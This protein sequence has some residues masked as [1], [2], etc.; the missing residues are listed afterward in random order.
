MNGDSQRNKVRVP[1]AFGLSERGPV[2]MVGGATGRLAPEACDHEGYGWSQDFYLRCGRCGAPMRL[3]RLLIARK[4]LTDIA[5]MERAWGLAG[6][7]DWMLEREGAGFRLVWAVPNEWVR[8][9][10]PL[11]AEFG[12]L[13]V[14]PAPMV[15]D[16][17]D[18]VDQV[19]G[20]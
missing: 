18:D 12:G 3:H 8:V 6:E 17:V 4:S 14:R 16:D 7:P 13:P 19:D 9:A 15:M 1:V 10:H 11:F 2:F 5:E 20:D